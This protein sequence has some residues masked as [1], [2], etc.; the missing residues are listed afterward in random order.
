MRRT[1]LI[2]AVALM[3]CTIECPGERRLEQR[4]RFLQRERGNLLQRITEL[5]SELVDLTA[6]MNF[7]MAGPVEVG[8]EDCILSWR[9]VRAQRHRLKGPNY[10]FL[11]CGWEGCWEIG[12]VHESDRRDRTDQHPVREIPAEVTDP[13]RWDLCFCRPPSLTADRTDDASRPR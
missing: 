1:A 6:T 12:W 3:G 11:T 8:K 13:S 4:M 9:Q 5:Q 7:L 10:G 2:C